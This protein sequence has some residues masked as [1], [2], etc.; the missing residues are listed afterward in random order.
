[1]LV[2]GRQD[3]GLGFECRTEAGPGLQLQCWVLTAQP[4]LRVRSR[5]EVSVS[6]GG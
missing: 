3:L 2:G 4:G 5:F 6:W 1:M